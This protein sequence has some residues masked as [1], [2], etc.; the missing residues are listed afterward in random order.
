MSLQNTDSNLFVKRGILKRDS[1]LGCFDIEPPVSDESREKRSVRLN[2]TANQATDLIWSNEFPPR[3]EMVR[4]NL[5]SCH[6]LVRS[7]TDGFLM[8]S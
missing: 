3:N 2:V 6:T 5:L 1:S 7:L 8:A 4:S